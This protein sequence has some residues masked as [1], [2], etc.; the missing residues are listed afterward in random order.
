MKFFFDRIKD[1]T[2]KHRGLKLLGTPTA[3]GK[4]LFAFN[5]YEGNKRLYDGVV[6]TLSKIPKA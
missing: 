1:H 3:K 2:T 5:S 4:C 6:G